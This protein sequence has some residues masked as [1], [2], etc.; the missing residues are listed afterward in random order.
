MK[1]GEFQTHAKDSDCTD[2]YIDLRRAP[3]RLSDSVRQQA[4]ADYETSVL[5][6]NH[7]QDSD[8]TIDAT[9]GLCIECGVDHGGLCP[10]CYGSGFHKLDCPRLKTYGGTTAKRKTA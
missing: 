10:Y 9:T 5:L 1:S 8:C 6:P 3:L 2:D 4:G 7:T